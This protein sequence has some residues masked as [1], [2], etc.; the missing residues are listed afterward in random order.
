MSVISSVQNSAVQLPSTTSEQA[1]APP[2][3]QSSNLAFLRAHDFSD[4]AEKFEE[5]FKLDKSSQNRQVCESDVNEAME[6]TR[7]ELRELVGKVKEAILFQREIFEKQEI[8]ANV[9]HLFGKFIEN[10]DKSHGSSSFQD[11]LT[12]IVTLIEEENCLDQTYQQEYEAL[13]FKPNCGKAT[14]RLKSTGAPCQVSISKESLGA[15]TYRFYVHPVGFEPTRKNIYWKRL[16]EIKFDIRK[17]N[18]SGVPSEEQCD[19]VPMVYIDDMCRKTGEYKDVGTMLLQV[20]LE[21]GFAEECEDAGLE[22]CWSSHAFHY[23]QGFRS[24]EAWINA[25]IAKIVEQN[26][27]TGVLKDTSG[28]FGVPMYLASEGKEYWKKQIREHP[29]LDTTKEERVMRL[30]R[31]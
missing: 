25:R 26:Q 7:F 15:H 4:L 16:G 5:L 14:V 6:T 18:S 21:E 10:I 17:K 29:I 8:Y 31:S 24:P 13:H 30:L 23:L 19:K 12:S 28:F 3:P 2:P 11:Q 9:E 1:S 20:A 22:A 27:S